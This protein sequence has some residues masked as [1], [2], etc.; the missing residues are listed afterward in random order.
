MKKSRECM[1]MEIMIDELFESLEMGY[2]SRDMEIKYIMGY[3]D[4]KLVELSE[5]LEVPDFDE[6]GEE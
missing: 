4:Q 2:L 3:I 5:K 1:E 6:E